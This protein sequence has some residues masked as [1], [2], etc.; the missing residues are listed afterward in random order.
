MKKTKTV[1]SEG[2]FIQA[3][4]RRFQPSSYTLLTQVSIPAPGGFR[5]VDALVLGRWASRDL[6]IH[7]FEIKTT[8]ANWLS[9]LNHPEKADAGA[10]ICNTWSIFAYPGVADTHEIPPLWGHWILDGDQLQ[11]KKEAPS[12]A[13][14]PLDRIV[15]IKFIEAALE[16]AQRNL[17]TISN[18]IE[19]NRG[20]EDGKKRGYHDADLTHGYLVQRVLDDEVRRERLQGTLRAL[21]LDEMSNHDLE[22]ISKITV[23]YKK[24]RIYRRPIE[25]ILEAID[26]LSSCHPKELR[27]SLEDLHRQADEIRNNIERRLEVIKNLFPTDPEAVPN[28]RP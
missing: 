6:D 19:Y 27:R 22:E 20:F 3:L 28:E 25:D 21:K 24:L 7:G 15:V 14:K 13:S 17:P 9:E 1:D 10:A 2:P 5:I 11:V 12:S 23:F 8:R 26:L 16:Q 4:R 18:E